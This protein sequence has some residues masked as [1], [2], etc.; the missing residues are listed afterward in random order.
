MPAK[1]LWSYVRITSTPITGFVAFAYAKPR[2]APRGL[3]VLAVYSFIEA[4]DIML[5]N[6]II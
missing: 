1:D 5:I 6:I 2:I 4:F 3:S